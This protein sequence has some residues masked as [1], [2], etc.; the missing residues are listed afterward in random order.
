MPTQSR[1][2][3]STEVLASLS[4]SANESASTS[5]VLLRHGETEWT[6]ARRIHGWF[7][8]PLS[9][10]GRQ[11][12]ELAAQRFAPEK[13]ERIY[14]SPLGRAME[15]A[16][17]IGRRI[18]Q[19]PVPLE[20]LRELGFGWLEGK[21]LPY[22]SPDLGGPKLLRPIVSLLLETTGEDEGQFRRR[23]ERAVNFI[24]RTHPDDRVL[25]VTHWAVLG[26][27]AVSFLDEGV[28]NWRGYDSWAACGVTEIQ[29]DTRGW[30]VLQ[31]NDTSH[32]AAERSE[33]K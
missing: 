17:I 11:Q 24:V 7:D 13:V 28:S 33:G 6:E 26:Q 15:T 2:N 25:V 5:L 18:G 1:E 21:P 19:A 10:L 30:H 27:L 8:R 4:M 31:W 9:P 22:F 29:R 16:E 32:L 14:S 3:N 12:A 20:D 23:V